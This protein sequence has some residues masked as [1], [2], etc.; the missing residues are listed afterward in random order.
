MGPQTPSSL[1]GTV[2][3]FL[4]SLGLMISWAISSTTTYILTTDSFLP[5]AQISQIS[6]HSR[7][8]WKIPGY[9]HRSQRTLWKPDTHHVQHWNYYLHH[10]TPVSAPVFP[11]FSN[12]VSGTVRPFDPTRTLGL[13]LVFL[14][15]VVSHRQPTAWFWSSL[16]LTLFSRPQGPAPVQRHTS[17]LLVPERLLPPG[18]PPRPPHPFSAPHPEWPL[19]HWVPMG[20]RSQ[21]GHSNKAH[22]SPRLPQPSLISPRLAAHA[23]TMTYLLTL[24]PR[25]ASSHL[26]LLPFPSNSCWP[27]RSPLRCLCP[28]QDLVGH[29]NL[30]RLAYVL[31]FMLLLCLW[32]YWHTWRSGC[33]YFSSPPTGPSALRTGP[34]TSS[35]EPSPPP[36]TSW[37]LSIHLLAHRMFTAR[38]T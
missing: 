31:S 27:H 21:P 7:Y 3:G 14:R 32:L 33:C 25:Q 1:R 24:Y 8:F 23:P 19:L 15:S 26:Q 22:K 20:P 13:V 37:I 18:L 12:A 28:Q 35:R 29:S 17:S 11:D 9:L 38:L 6:L 4:S 2:L 5:L 36:E 16:W 34:L 10:L 30:P